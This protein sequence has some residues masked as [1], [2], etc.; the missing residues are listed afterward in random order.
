MPLAGLD[1]LPFS[2]LPKNPFAAARKV[3]LIERESRKPC[4]KVR[5]ICQFPFLP[6][7][8]GRSFVIN[9]SS[10]WRFHEKKLMERVNGSILHTQ[11]MIT[12]FELFL[13][14]VTWIAWWK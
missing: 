3:R 5:K 4:P 13:Q 1:D 10:D 9:P 12:V 11:W 2:A 14:E 8:F 6:G 7:S